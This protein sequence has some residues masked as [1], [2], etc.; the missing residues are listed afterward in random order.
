MREKS[1]FVV[2][3]TTVDSEAKARKLAVAIVKQKLAACVQYSRI[4]SVYRWKGA[5]ESA[6]EYILAAKTRQT[7]ADSVIKFI[8][9]NHSY[10]VPEIIV[11][12]IIKGFA[13]YLNWIFAET[14][15]KR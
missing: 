2:V 9:A 13:G 6:D 10:E 8:K 4:R 1:K 7:M 15:N 14:K 11:T 12:P 5:V 3:N